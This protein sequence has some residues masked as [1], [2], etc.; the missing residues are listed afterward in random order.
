MIN[1]FDLSVLNFINRTLSNQLLNFIMPVL[2]RIGG[3]ELYFVIGL[4]L[5]F[6]RKREFKVLGMALLAGLTV[7]YYVV[8]L[9]KISIA[10]PRPFMALANVILLGPV[11]KG[12]S[13][14]S[15]HAATAFMTASLLANHFKR[16]FL[17]YLL[18]ALIGFSRIYMGVHYPSD[19]LT[20]AAI[21][22]TIGYLLTGISRKF[23]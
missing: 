13:F 4:V 5:L 14:P 16:Y 2:S 1:F 18:A 8:G 22:I 11:E 7:S 20:G 23:E 17:F 12:Y 9:L 10:R 19:V 21:G 15:G 3:N 6:S